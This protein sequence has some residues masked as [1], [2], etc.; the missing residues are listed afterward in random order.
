M[1]NESVVTERSTSVGS[2][3]G[4]SAMASRK[5]DR[6]RCVIWTPL[7]RPVDPDV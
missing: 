7:G 5:F 2:R 4:W 6:A 3:P 1:S